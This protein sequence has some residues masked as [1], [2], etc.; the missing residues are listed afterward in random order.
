[1]HVILRVVV[2]LLALPGFLALAV[3]VTFGLLI[4]SRLGGLTG[5]VY[6]AAIEISEVAFLTAACAAT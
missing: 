4:Q 6:G 5:D 3:A 1:M 2:V